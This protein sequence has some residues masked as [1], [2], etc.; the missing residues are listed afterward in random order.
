M[1]AKASASRTAQTIAENYKQ[2]VF[3]MFDASEAIR[4]DTEPGFMSEFFATFS[5]IVGQKQRATMAY[6]LQANGTAEHMVQNLTRAIRGTCGTRIRKI[7][8]NMPND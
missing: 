8:M 4:H 3:R 1:D 2:C 5:R 6:R 7:G